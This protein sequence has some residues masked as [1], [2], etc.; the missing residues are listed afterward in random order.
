M[1][2]YIWHLILL[3][4]HWETYRAP[5]WQMYNFFSMQL[6]FSRIPH[7]ISIRMNYYIFFHCPQCSF[8]RIR[9]G[10]LIWHCRIIIMCVFSKGAV[11]VREHFEC[12]LCVLINPAFMANRDTEIFIKVA[13]RTGLYF[14]FSVWG[15]IL[16]ISRFLVRYDK[17]SR[18]QSTVINF[19]E[20]EF[21][22]GNWEIMNWRLKVCYVKKRYFRDVAWLK[23]IIFIIL[24]LNFAF[25][26]NTWK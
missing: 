17:Q 12:F 8:V 5:L 23:I 15:W 4:F 26:V 20:D 2:K 13:K 18:D 25:F 24:Q 14:F 7:V 16:L 1:K 11:Y 22:V 3:N 10:F 19:R 21:F 6:I 9:V